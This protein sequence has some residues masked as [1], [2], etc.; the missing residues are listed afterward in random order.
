M[1]RPEKLIV[2]DGWGRVEIRCDNRGLSHMTTSNE[3]T[4]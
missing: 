1:L 3:G 4:P 2:M